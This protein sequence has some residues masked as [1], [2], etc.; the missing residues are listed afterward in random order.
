[1]AEQQTPAV[2]VVSSQQHRQEL[3]RIISKFQFATI[4]PQDFWDEIL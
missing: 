4:S 3:P 1:M 2:L